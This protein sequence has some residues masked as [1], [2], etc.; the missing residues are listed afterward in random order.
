MVL[1]V[2]GPIAAPQGELQPLKPSSHA[3]L[4]F[5]LVRPLVLVFL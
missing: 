4:L 2:D 5:A 3:T 1:D